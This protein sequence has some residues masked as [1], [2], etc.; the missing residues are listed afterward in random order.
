MTKWCG[1]YI[2]KLSSKRIQEIQ[3]EHKRREK[4]RK[5]VHF[6]KIPD[7]QMPLDEEYTL[8]NNGHDVESDEGDGDDYIE[9]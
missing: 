5:E 9:T 1:E 3:S 2:Q 4:K 8:D 7:Y 6:E